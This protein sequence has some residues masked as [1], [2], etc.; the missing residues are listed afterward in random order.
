VS[1]YRQRCFL[2]N[3]YLLSVYDGLLH[4]IRHCIIPA[5]ETASLKPHCNSLSWPVFKQTTVSLVIMIGSEVAHCLQGGDIANFISSDSIVVMASVWQLLGAIVT[6]KLIWIPA[7]FV[8]RTPVLTG[9]NISLGETFP[10]T[11]LRKLNRPASQKVI[12]KSTVK[13]WAC[14]SLDYIV[15]P[16]CCFILVYAMRPVEAAGRL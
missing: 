6:W 15:A 11:Y 4:I 14:R 9:T 7:P 13:L 8:A 16:A 1:S 5:V 3:P 10:L 12:L 2:L